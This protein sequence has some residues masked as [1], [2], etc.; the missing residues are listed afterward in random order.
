MRGIYK[1]PNYF[2]T[3]LA[4]LITKILKINPSDR[5]TC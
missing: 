3:E 2:S 4:E 1:I 5:P